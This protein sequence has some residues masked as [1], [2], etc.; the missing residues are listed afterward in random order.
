M[1][2]NYNECL[3]WLETR[4]IKLHPHQEYM[5]DCLCEERPFRAAR[6]LGR[7]YTVK[8]YTSYLAYLLDLNPRREEVQIVFPY[9]CAVG[10][11][12][13]YVD[14]VESQRE[15]CSADEFAK[16]FEGR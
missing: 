7:T 16:N 14:Y 8:A 9:T 15:E 11:D 3:R 2:V 6:G 5:L 10:S 4:G 13:A 12:D 1:K